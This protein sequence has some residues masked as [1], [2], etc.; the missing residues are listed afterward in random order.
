MYAQQGW[1]FQ[2]AE[3]SWQD[4][5]PALSIEGNSNRKGGRANWINRRKR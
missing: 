4:A 5:N 1:D 2:F 3:S